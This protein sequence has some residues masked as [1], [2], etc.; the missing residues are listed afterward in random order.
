MKAFCSDDFH[1]VTWE[2]EANLSTAANKWGCQG[3]CAIVDN[4]SDLRIYKKG[5][6]TKR[7]DAFG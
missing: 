5:K 1:N 3:S 6:I 7:I 2:K 4:N